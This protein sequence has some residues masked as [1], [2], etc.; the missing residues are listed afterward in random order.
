VGPT[1]DRGEQRAMVERFARER[2]EALLYDAQSPALLDVFSGKAL[3][4]DWTRVERVAE[5]RN[6][7]TGAPYLSLLLENERQVLLADVGIAFAPDT[8]ATGPL[9]GLPPVVCFRDFAATEGRLTHYL[10]D[11]PDDPPT[12]S[13]LDLFFFL[14]AVLDGARA[15]GFEVSREERRLEGLLGEIEARRGA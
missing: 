13:H 12:R 7:E 4:L 6:S 9:P 10:L 15:V 5:G 8:A 11:H 2:P 14:L 3:P 1:A